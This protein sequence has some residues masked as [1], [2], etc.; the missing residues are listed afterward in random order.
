MGLLQPLSYIQLSRK[1]RHVT[2]N[3]NNECHF[4]DKV[5]WV[6]APELCGW[7]CG[8]DEANDQ[9]NEIYFLHLP[10]SNY[11]GPVL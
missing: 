11:I 7:T 9:M 6:V 5:L 3:D 1:I 10:L 4:Y 2:S 8:C